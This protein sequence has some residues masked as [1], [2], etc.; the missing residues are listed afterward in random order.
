MARAAG[1][2]NASR[3]VGGVLRRNPIRLPHL[4]LTA[5]G[6]GAAGPQ[7]PIGSEQACTLGLRF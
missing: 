2:P 1:N 4:V 6:V 5:S 7:Q 3:A